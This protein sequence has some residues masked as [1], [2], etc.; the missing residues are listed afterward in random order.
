MAPPKAT[1]YDQVQ[2]DVNWRSR[3]QSEEKSQFSA[4]RERLYNLV[5]TEE[6]K[7]RP[8]KKLFSSRD[9]VPLP[10]YPMPPKEKKQNPDFYG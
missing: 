5:E 2:Q 4:Q 1:E 6:G 10:E 8:Q 3:I 9:C 7:W